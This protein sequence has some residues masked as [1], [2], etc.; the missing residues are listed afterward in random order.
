MPARTNAFQKLLARIQKASFPEGTIVEE[1]KMVP[2]AKLVGLREIDVYVETEKNSR[3]LKIA[4][5][6]MDR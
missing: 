3:R 6:A 4:F 5:E 1:S 2:V